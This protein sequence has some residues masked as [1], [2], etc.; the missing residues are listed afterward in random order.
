M[1]K[2]STHFP[3]GHGAD[4][5]GWRKYTNA[6]K[7]HANMPLPAPVAG[8]SPV[9]R[10]IVAKANNNVAA[11]M[12]DFDLVQSP[13]G[14]D[15]WLDLHFQQ[16]IEAINERRAYLANP[17]SGIQHVGWTDA[18][19][20][21][22]WSPIAITHGSFDTWGGTKKLIDFLRD[23]LWDDGNELSL[24]RWFGGNEKVRNGTACWLPFASETEFLD[25]VKVDN[26]D[27]GDIL[28]GFGPDGSGKYATIP[29]RA[30][31]ALYHR[32]FADYSGSIPMLREHIN[33]LYACLNTLN[34]RV[35][36][37]LPWCN[38]TNMGSNV[39]RVKDA[40]D[41][42][43]VYQTAHA[44]AVGA[45]TDAG[46]I[47]ALPALF[48]NG[49]YKD[50]S[51][52]EDGLLVHGIQALADVR[53]ESSPLD[54]NWHM[55]YDEIIDAGDNPVVANTV[56]GLADDFDSTPAIPSGRF[57]PKTQVGMTAT[58]ESR[59]VALY[60]NLAADQFKYK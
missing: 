21:S 53:V 37:L 14:S 28:E 9:P 41:G 36:Q 12:Y 57:A 44:A 47:A 51:W 8:Y 20:A 52:Y 4:M 48:C 7:A 49:V 25:Q 33:S 45:M 17:A 46:V 26:E 3:Q 1:G 56:V 50:V 39:T 5:I 2:R 16:I 13:L 59:A 35:F 23:M 54:A 29:A 43:P 38:A 11:E 6:V 24:A 27:A 60:R 55:V 31:T 18:E 10:L 42:Y 40:T 22:L 30:G 34:R 32:R 58:I 19:W 15:G